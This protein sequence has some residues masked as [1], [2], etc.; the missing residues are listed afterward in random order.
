LKNRYRE[1]LG[2]QVYGR[3]PIV[4]DKGT[5]RKYGNDREIGII[6]DF[7]FMRRVYNKQEQRF[8]YFY[9]VISI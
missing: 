3:L 8:K 2:N 6:A 4:L 5:G 1:K 9:F 7:F